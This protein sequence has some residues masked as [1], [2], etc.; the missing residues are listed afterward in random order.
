MSNGAKRDNG[1]FGFFCVI[2]GKGMPWLCDAEEK[3]LPVFP[4][5]ERMALPSISVVLYLSNIGF[6]RENYLTRH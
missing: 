2:Y 1:C 3:R 6:L 4:L 5:T